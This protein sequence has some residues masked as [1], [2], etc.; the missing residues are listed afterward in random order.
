MNRPHFRIDESILATHQQRFNNFLLDLVMRFFIM[1]GV[2]IVIV[3]IMMSQGYTEAEIIESPE[4]LSKVG[5]Y[6]LG[7]VVDLIYF[8]FFEIIFARTV[9]KFITK[10]VVVDEFGRKPTI[11]A[12]LMRSI[13]RAIPFEFLT[14]IGMPS[15]G[16]HDQFSNTYVVQQELLDAKKRTY[17]SFNVNSN[18]E[19]QSKI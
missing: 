17:N 18:Q 12:I 6:A 7:L 3:V 16:W 5:Q 4:R 19:T 11:N 15:R 10:T 8:N 9:G 2:F 13:C 14:F 1:F